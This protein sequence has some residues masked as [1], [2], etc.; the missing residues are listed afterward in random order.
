M[1][2][3]SAVRDGWNGVARATLV[4]C[5]PQAGGREG[6][7]LDGRG[8]GAG[9]ASWIRWCGRIVGSQMFGRLGEADRAKRIGVCRVGTFGYGLR[10]GRVRGANM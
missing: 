5:T 4:G 1:Q 2:G 7:R 9:R 10:A 6:E 8:G 3:G